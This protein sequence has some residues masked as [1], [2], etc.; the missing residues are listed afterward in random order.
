MRKSQVTR[1]T[2]MSTI[3]AAVLLA[4]R[5]G[6]GGAPYYCVST[7]WVR[8]AMG[9]LNYGYATLWVRQAMGLLRCVLSLRHSLR[10]ALRTFLWGVVGCLRL[11]R[12]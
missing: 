4:P 5:I 12:Y 9:T 8:I 3:H 2:L 10:Q 11:L 6:G 7:Q 1:A